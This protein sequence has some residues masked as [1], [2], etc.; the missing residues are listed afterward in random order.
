ME[1]AWFVD[2]KSDEKT[3]GRLKADYLLK[4][5]E[6]IDDDGAFVLIINA[7]LQ[8]SVS[9]QQIGNIGQM[10]YRIRETLMADILSWIGRH[11]TRLGHVYLPTP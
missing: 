10:A 1:H 4:T 6:F 2:Y 7:N 8:L 9:D 5:P 11:I 3:E